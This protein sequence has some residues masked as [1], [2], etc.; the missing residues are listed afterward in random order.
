METSESETTGNMG[1]I[2]NLPQRVLQIPELSIEILSNFADN[3]ASIRRTIQSSSVLY[4]F[5][6][7]DNGSNMLA[8][9]LFA[10]RYPTIQFPTQVYDMAQRLTLKDYEDFHCLFDTLL[11]EIGDLKAPHERFPRTMNAAGKLV[12]VFCFR[13]KEFI[14]YEHTLTNLLA[15]K[16]IYNNSHYLRWESIEHILRY[17]YTVHFPW[18][19]K[20]N[21]PLEPQIVLPD[22]IIDEGTDEEFDDYPP[23][24]GYITPQEFY[25]DPS[26]LLEDKPFWSYL[27]EMELTT[28]GRASVRMITS[29]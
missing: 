8:R 15:T 29:E 14:D 13:L 21:S 23:A 9:R 7:S 24:R 17:V 11:T 5:F 3:P 2:I 4:R 10:K 19:V 20:L 27:K 22:E 12:D 18:R 26:R 6:S 16:A 28:A 25:N 1:A